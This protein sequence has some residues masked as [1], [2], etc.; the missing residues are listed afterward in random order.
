MAPHRLWGRGRSGG[1]FYLIDLWGSRGA[2]LG[3]KRKGR[4][5]KGVGCMWTDVG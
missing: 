2:G 1:T 4:G 5:K 3:F